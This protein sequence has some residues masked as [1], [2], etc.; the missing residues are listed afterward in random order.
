MR[1]L[2]PGWE[3]LPLEQVL[4]TLP[5][6]AKV[7]QGWSP[8]CE[9]ESAGPEE[10]GV[11]KTTA[12]QA[13]A[14]SDEHHKRLP[15]HL[16]PRPGIE[17][18]SGD[19]LLT[20]AGPRARCGIPCLVRATRPRLLLSGKVYRFRADESLMDPRFL[21]Y[22]L[23]DAETQ[24]AIDQMK[25][26]ISDS[27]LNLTQSRFA[28][29]PVVVP[30]LND[31]RQIIEILADHLSRL[32]A[33]ASSLELASR[34]VRLLVASATDAVR[35]EAAESGPEVSLGRLAVAS[36][37]GTSAKCVANGLGPAVVRIP[38]LVGGTIDLSDEKRVQDGSL[39]VS[40][41][42]LDPG[43]LLF[44]RTNGSRDLIGRTGVVQEGVRAAFA[45][46]LI[47]YKLDVARL[48]PQWIHLMM[49]TPGSRR[50][51]ESMAASSAGQ[52][53]LSLSK[54]DRVAVPV[55]T[56]DEQD[57]LLVRSRGIEEA[58]GRLDRDLTSAH[59][60]RTA[61]RRSLLT[62]AFAGRLT[63][64]ATDDEVVQ[65]LANL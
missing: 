25:T 43:D 45:S 29:L 2:P 22:F 36:G 47:R 42:M 41:L 38:N 65:E 52:Y 11:L 30:P 49:R 5:S 20:N 31:Q 50:L 64:R 18:R 4:E 1:S 10:W 51:L 37:Y 26:G 6:G 19:L 44:V 58:A 59:L 39:D 62:A 46:Y 13:G 12:I 9:K 32:D 8:Q 55:P 16:P 17:V 23:L 56:L 61:L 28:A 63:S 53:N 54:L 48:R 27:G 35:S 24:Q 60:R 21:E 14:F 34:H 7:Q 33:A 40:G 3:W 15:A 57:R